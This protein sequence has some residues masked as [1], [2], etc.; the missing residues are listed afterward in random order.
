[1]TELDFEAPS[2]LIWVRL[3]PVSIG[4]FHLLRDLSL[5]VSLLRLFLLALLLAILGLLLQLLCYLSLQLL[6]V[7]QERPLRLLGRVREVS[8]ILQ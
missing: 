4:L 5:E 8:L 6:I 3:D 7:L 2:D 1:M